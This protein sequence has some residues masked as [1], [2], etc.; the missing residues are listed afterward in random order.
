MDRRILQV[1][2]YVFFIYAYILSEATRGV[3]D[4]RPFV[5]LWKLRIPP[6]AAFAWRLIRN[7]LPT[8]ANLRKR[9]VEIS[10]VTCPLCNNMEEDAAHLFFQ[11][12]RILPLWWESL[13][14]VGKKAVFPQ[15]PIEHF[16][17]HTNGN[18]YSIKDTRWKCW[19]IALT[20]TIWQHRNKT[21]FDTHIFNTRKV[22]D[23]AL[24]LLWSWLK[25]MEKDF[26][27]HYNQW[28]SQLGDVFG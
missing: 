26:T 20:W 21:V 23:D 12:S 18:V 10:D 14:W 2:N 16:M 19:W 28:S 4:N 22:M 8:K 3:V 11:C 7:R 24:L 9:Q 6:K 5:E 15:N 17:Q 27:M 13:L 25:V 1:I